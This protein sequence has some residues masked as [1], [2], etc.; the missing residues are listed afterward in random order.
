MSTSIKFSTLL[1]AALLSASAAAQAVIVEPFT[2]GQLS[3]AGWSQPI[4]ADASIYLSQSA[5]DGTYGIA[6][7]EGQ[8]S[9]NTSI[10]FLPGETLSAWINPGPGPN[11]DPNDQGGRLYVGF[12]AGVSG[13]YSFVAASDT[14][15]LGFQDNSN[16]YALPDFSNAVNQNYADQWY[17]LTVTLS[18][19]GSSA[20]ANVYNNDGSTLLNTLTETGLSVT[21]NTGIALRGLGGAAI[22]SVA[23]VPLPGTFWL[24]A[25]A[26]GLLPALRRRK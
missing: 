6:L 26:A 2:G 13:A 11:T 18:S 10:N 21:G 23:I 14:E 25:S 12:D 17:L 4:G 1:G 19:D 20:T 9:Y 22:T 15:Q 16:N 7:S 3:A 8:W 5:P 24:F